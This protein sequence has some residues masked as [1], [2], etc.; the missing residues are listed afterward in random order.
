M[1]HTRFDKEMQEEAGPKTTVLDTSQFQADDTQLGV[2]VEPLI[3][4]ANQIAGGQESSAPIQMPSR[5]DLTVRLVSISQLQ[6]LDE[7][8]NDSSLFQSI[9]FTI[10]GVLLGLPI[11]I[12]TSNVSMSKPLWAILWVLAGVTLIF[13]CLT[14]RASRSA[15]ELRRKIFG[16]S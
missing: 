10:V 16:K 4:Y 12:Y 5:E 7:L 6:R 9:L 2:I 3:R 14:I 8:R 13:A 15:A 1:A 11:T